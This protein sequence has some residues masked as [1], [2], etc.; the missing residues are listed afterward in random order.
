[1]ASIRQALRQC[2]WLRSAYQALRSWALTAVCRVSPELLARL[3]YRVAWG[4]WPNITNPK[5]FDEK[6]IWL[7]LYWRHPLK[8]ECGDEYTLR[9]YVERRGLGELLPRLFGVY[10]MC[11]QSTST[12]C[13]KRAC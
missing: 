12:G 2:T 11:K 8:T 4:R 9:Q 7:N 5:T 6:L 1:M 3:R 13:Q 10:T